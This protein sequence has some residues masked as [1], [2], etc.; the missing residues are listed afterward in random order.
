MIQRIQVEDKLYEIKQVFKRYPDSNEERLI[1]IKN[2]LR[3]EALI[4]NDQFYF[5]CNEITNAQFTD[6]LTE[7]K[8]V[9]KINNVE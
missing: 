1:Q 7:I 4:K 9:T 3:C 8:Q 5:L 6:I 2:N